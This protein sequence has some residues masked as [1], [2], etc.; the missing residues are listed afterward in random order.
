MILWFALTAMIA[1]AAV[2]AAAPFIRRH[3][4]R[5]L[6]TGGEVAVYRDQLRE[7]EREAAAGQI[8]AAQ[9]DL[10]RV[11]I[12]RRLIAAGESESAMLPPLSGG[13]RTLAAIGVS[14]VVV[15]GSI[16]LLAL[17]GDSEPTSES[18]VAMEPAMTR[19]APRQTAT[20]LVTPPAAS[21]MGAT[22]AGK[23]S[24]L[25]PVEE[26]IQKL[27]ARLQKNPKDVE[28]WRMLGWSYFGTDHYSEAAAAYARA[29]ELNPDSA[30][31]RDSRVESMVRAEKGVVSADAR[32][33]NEETLKTHPKDARARYIKG[34]ALDQSGD[35][36]GAQKTW[37]ELLAEL[38]EK[39][40]A[41]QDIRRKIAAGGK[42]PESPAASQALATTERGP[43]PE[44]VKAAEA[45]SPADRQAMIARMVDQLADRLE[46]EPNDLEGWIKLIRSRSVLGDQDKA[47]AAVEG[48][49]KAFSEGSADHKR[50]AQTAEE[51]G[52]NK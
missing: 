13:E 10:A 4:R 48:A 22:G 40:P 5:R 11:E 49:M 34:L 20:A 33:A 19:P 1:V 39:E 29:I 7:V 32:D 9:A 46:R 17:S 24:A 3:E 15:F 45:M 50:I 6:E 14:A 35:K 51:L 38:D 27:V 36:D 26:L 18:S 31:L 21:A 43:R 16:A 41:A 37:T 30:D 2:F 23:R 28:G 52:L 12:Q 44:D 8:D 25:P 42:E 47:K